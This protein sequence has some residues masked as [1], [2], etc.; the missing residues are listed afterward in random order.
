MEHYQK[1]PAEYQR[2]LTRDY[3]VLGDLLQAAGSHQE[4]EQAYSRAIELNP[5]DSAVWFGRA[6]T[7]GTTGQHEKAIADYTKLIEL[8]PTNSAAWNNR[9][10]CYS[11]L[12]QLDK[13]L[14]NYSK[15]IELRPNYALSWHNRGRVHAQ[16]GQWDKSIADFTK[17]IE[18]KPSEATYWVNRA[19][20]QLNRRQ[21]DKAIADF[22]KAIELKP[23]Y[24]EAW[25]G[26][27]AAQGQLKQIEKAIADYSE[28]IKLKP[29][30]PLA[31]HNRAS[32]YAAQG[33]WDKAIADFAK[34]VALVPT[35]AV[36][37]N[38]LAWFLV[39]CPDPKFRDPSK[40]VKLA[41]KAVEMAPKE[42]NH[43][44]TLGVAHYRARD[45]KA[46]TAALEKSK[47]LLGDTELGFNAFFLA[48]AHWHLGGKP[49]AR[50]WHSQA[51]EW[52]EKNKPDD[53]ELRRFRAEAEELM[54]SEK[55]TKPK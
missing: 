4:A 39:T 38:N 43:W 18:L 5:T 26:R 48:M 16:L 2:S 17:T 44:N 13:A 25:N 11:N 51:V 3:N 23:D 54:K 1:L 19:N 55:V 6:Y 21:Y 8:D 22:S 9:G 20:A 15:A 42:G 47:E 7:Y 14:E 31:L 34:V 33:Q 12:S 32:L 50:Q 46:A 29:D 40:A 27:G 10:V 35:N 37:H 45:W 52:M 28:A 53:Q 49:E 30:F 36:E 24:A 41:Q